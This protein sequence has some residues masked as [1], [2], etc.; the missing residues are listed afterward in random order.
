MAEVFKIINGFAPPIMEDFF[1]LC[2]NSDNIRNFQIISNESKK[3]I[4]YG[5]EMVKYRTPL[6]CANLPE[7]YKTA[8]SLNSFKTKIKTWKCETCVY[9]LCQIYHQNLGFL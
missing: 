4:R 6:L 5:L 8:T 9:R 3:S 7:K 1:L 2:E